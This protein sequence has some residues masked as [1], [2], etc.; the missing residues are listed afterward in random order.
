M[1]ASRP[2]VERCRGHNEERPL[3]HVQ[4]IERRL[5]LML[6]QREHVHVRMP[7]RFTLRLVGQ[8][9][10]R[11]CLRTSE[12][13]FRQAFL[14]PGLHVSRRLDFE[15]SPVGRRQVPHRPL[16]SGPA[17]RSDG[18][19]D[20]ILRENPPCSVANDVRRAP[21][22]E[23]KECGTESMPILMEQLIT[24]PELRFDAA[25]ISH[26]PSWPMDT[27]NYDSA[28]CV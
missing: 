22:P 2:T 8:W 26:A 10:I 28:V 23:I 16:L 18:G 12:G 17:G 15:S 6:Q 14:L 5:V 9:V 20:E 1:L 21:P 13:H 19:R 7:A 25:Q 27:T 11:L 4:G 3:R 24:I